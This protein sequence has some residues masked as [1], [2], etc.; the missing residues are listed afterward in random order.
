MKPLAILFSDPNHSQKEG[1]LHGW[2]SGLALPALPVLPMPGA[3]S[4]QGMVRVLLC[5]ASWWMM[6]TLSSAFVLSPFL[7][8]PFICTLTLGI[9]L[10]SYPAKQKRPVL[11]VEDELIRKR[12]DLRSFCFSWFK[13]LSFSHYE[14]KEVPV[15][16]N[17]SGATYET[18]ATMKQSI[19]SVGCLCMP[20][21][22]VF[23]NFISKARSK[24]CS[25]SSNDKMNLLPLN[26]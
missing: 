23:C 11:L 7:R 19:D 26:P 4:W 9:S 21:L 22:S 1:Q 16:H 6:T 13:I 15:I 25:G 3:A 24:C 12:H 2:W 20:R 14:R 5:C 18:E 10:P 8:T 17:C